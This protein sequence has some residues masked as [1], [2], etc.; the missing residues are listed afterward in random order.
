MA[1]LLNPPRLESNRSN[2]T[3]KLRSTGFGC[4]EGSKL[5][6]KHDGSDQIERKFGWKGALLDTA[7]ESTATHRL[8]LDHLG[9]L[10]GHGQG[11]LEWLGVGDDANL[12]FGCAILR[13]VAYLDI[14]ELLHTHTHIR[15]DIDNTSGYESHP[16]TIPCVQVHIHASVQVLVSR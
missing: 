14:R 7:C 6:E 5:P 13:P 16:T 4:K 11:D 12:Q 2:P 8:C 1:S 15:P 3:K 9:R 10:W